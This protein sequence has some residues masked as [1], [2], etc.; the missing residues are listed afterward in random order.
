MPLRHRGLRHTANARTGPAL[1]STPLRRTPS[2]GSGKPPPG[3]LHA[4]LKRTR[5]AAPTHGE[6]RDAGRAQESRPTAAEAARIRTSAN[7][8]AGTGP[9]FFRLPSPRFGTRRRSCRAQPA[10]RGKTHR[11]VAGGLG[12]GRRRRDLAGAG[13][14]R[15]RKE[16]TGEPPGRGMPERLA[17]EQGRLHEKQIPCPQH[18]P[19]LRQGG[20]Q[21]RPQGRHGPD[22]ASRDGNWR[23][24]S[25]SHRIR[26]IS[27][28]PDSG[29]LCNRSDVVTDA[30]CRA[31][32]LGV[33]PAASSC[34]AA[35][36]TATARTSDGSYSC[37]V[38]ARCMYRLPDGWWHMPHWTTSINVPWTELGNVHNCHGYL[39]PGPC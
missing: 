1:P 27:C 4:I 30:G 2:A 5:P 19:G 32:F 31:R 35:S 9:A 6:R 37:T 22:P 39:R 33:S 28:C 21:G 18:V 16:R 25:T 17:G 12:A 7:R 34:G 20:R 10:Q 14:R 11:I 8:I 13:G 29:D 26:Q 24:G 38:T 3:S 23:N 36:L 15:L